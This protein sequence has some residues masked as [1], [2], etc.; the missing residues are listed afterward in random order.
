MN[1]TGGI[2]GSISGNAGSFGL[3]IGG[4]GGAGGDAGAVDVHVTGNVIASGVGS[5]VRTE[6][7]TIEVEVGPDIVEIEVPGSRTRLNGSNGVVAQ[8]VGGGGG[9]GGVNITG[10]ISL[11]RPGGG[12]VAG[13]AVSIGIG[14][15]GGD[16]GDAGAVNLT[17][18]PL[19][20][21]RV[22]VSANGDGSIAAMAQSVGGGGGNGRINVSGSITMD[23]QLTAGIGGFGGDGGLGRD[24]TAVV[25]ADLFAAGRGSRGLAAQSIGGG[26]CHGGLGTLGGRRTNI[27]T[28]EPSLVFGIGGFGGAGNAS[29]DVTVTQNG[30]IMVEG[31]ESI[32]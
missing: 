14:G 6:A 8:S 32:G 21:D 31:K 2:S 28:E 30:L 9:D 25:D 10:S 11:T 26:C 23:G 16:G 18:L 1:V 19:G 15:F 13:R 4:F 20:A 22:Q 17:I 29:G 7:E 5:D 27:D 24:V 3:G 12:A